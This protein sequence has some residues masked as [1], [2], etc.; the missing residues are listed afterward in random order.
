MRTPTLFVIIV[1]LLTVADY[2]KAQDITIDTTTLSSGERLR[3]VEETLKVF[4]SQ[5]LPKDINLLRKAERELKAILEMDSSSVYRAQI[6]ADLEIVNEGLAFHDL[7]VAAF[8]MQ[9]GHRLLAARS[10]LLNII[11]SYPKFSKMD[12]VLYRLV[13]VSIDQEKEDDTVRFGWTLTCNYPT[14]EY[15]TPAFEHVNKI[16]VSSWEGCQKYKLPR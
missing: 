7:Q 8:Y 1:L 11:Q 2:C 10:R 9:Y 5:E 13:V 12:E 16:G 3:L 14:S 4:K 15:A 6:E